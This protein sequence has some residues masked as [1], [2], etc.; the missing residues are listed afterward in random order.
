VN[1]DARDIGAAW[2]GRD[3]K[4]RKD[5]TQQLSEIEIQEC[6]L[7]SQRIEEGLSTEDLSIS[8]HTWL[9]TLTARLQQIQNDLEYASGAV[10]LHGFPLKQV[11]RKNA[12]VLFFCMLEKIGTPIS[13][14]IQGD[15]VFHVRDE[16]YV[17]NDPRARGPSSSKRLTFHSD[18]CDVIGFLCFQPAKQG[19]ENQIVSSVA[20]YQRMKEERPDLLAVLQQPFWYKRHNVDSGNEHAYYQQPVFSF[21]EGR[22][23][24]SLLRV[25]IDRAYD[26]GDT[27][28]MTST[29]RE[30]LDLI[31][32]WSLD[33]SMHLEFRQKSGDI[34]LLNNFVTLHRRK[35]FEDHAEVEQRRHLL[36]VWLSMP[37]SRPLHP[38]FKS[39]YGNTKAGAIRGGMRRV[40]S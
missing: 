24:S 12:E 25:L 11:G 8:F 23:A 34:L 31:E 19:G 7:A 33:P 38:L 35:A 4:E 15:K 27:P 29:Q 28:E 21:H 26:S 40:G 1:L 13:Q 10:T 17:S 18:R 2:L 22:F 39:S 36:R 32:T 16:G 3:L 9:P 6:V 20:L 37:N 5:W 30:A 14:S